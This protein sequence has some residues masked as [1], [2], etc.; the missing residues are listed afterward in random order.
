MTGAT[1]ISN[2]NILCRGI[3]EGNVRIFDYVFLTY[4]SGLVT[5]A[6]RLGIDRMTSEDVVQDFFMK[7]WNRRE[8]I[9]FN[10]SLKSYLFTS[11]RNRCLDIIK[12]RKVTDRKMQEHT[13]FSKEASDSRDYLV[14]SELQQRIDLALEHLPEKCRK[15]F[16]MNQIEGM[17]PSEIAAMENI[18]VRTVEGHIGKAYR[19]LR[20]ELGDMLFA[21][22][23]IMTGNW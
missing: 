19:L 21:I 11:V 7:L 22:F 2:D 13:A 1:N 20:Q 12:H 23:L 18:S 8:D 17:R 16:V 6:M 5:Y 15:I 14:E 9:I 4:Y 10:T 3:A